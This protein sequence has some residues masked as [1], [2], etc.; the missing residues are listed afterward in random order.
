MNWDKIQSLFAVVLVGSMI[1]II[2]VFLG[3]MLTML[4]DNNIDSSFCE[5]NY[6]PKVKQKSFIYSDSWASSELTVEEG[7]INCCRYKYEDHIGEP[8]CKVFKK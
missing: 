3:G 8:E 7:Y 1:L 4:I 5:T 6:P 2:V